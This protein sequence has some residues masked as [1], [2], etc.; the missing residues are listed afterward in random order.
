[1]AFLTQ[2]SEVVGFEKHHLTRQKLRNPK[3]LGTNHTF[4]TGHFTP[5]IFELNESTKKCFKMTV[6]REPVDRAVSA[7]FFHQHEPEEVDK[8]LTSKMRRVNKSISKMRK[9]CRLWWQYSNDMTRQIAGLSDTKWHTGLED[10]Y[11]ISSITNQTHLDRAK[12]H[13]EKD[14]DA[15]CYLHDLPSCAEK[16]MK[17][18][19]LNANDLD[20]SMMV[21]DKNSAFR[22]KSRPKK[23]DDEII[24]KFR[25][26]NNIDLELYNWTLSRF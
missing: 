7:F 11:M 6:L 2:L 25:K 22:T 17:A 5:A 1:M 24:E 21:A 19:H 26:V 15:V 14:F 12:E 18:F 20:V 3:N 8:C 9:N 10:P 4:I 13:L 16:V 23:V